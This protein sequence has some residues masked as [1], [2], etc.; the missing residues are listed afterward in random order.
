MKSFFRYFS[1]IGAILFTVISLSVL[2]VRAQLLNPQMYTDALEESGVYS[3]ISDILETKTTSY[4]ISAQKQLVSTIAD[5]YNPENQVVQKLEPVVVLFLDS[6]IDRETEKA[7]SQV[8]EKLQVESALKNG[9]AGVITYSVDWLAGIREDPKFLSYIPDPERLTEIK[10]QGAVPFFVSQVKQD[11]GVEDLPPCET[12]TQVTQNLSTIAQGKISDVTCYS[13]EIKAVVERG[14]EVAAPKIA[15]TQLAMTVND[16]LE[17]YQIRTL[18]EDLFNSL[19]NIAYLKQDLYQLREYVIQSKEWAVNGFIISLIMLVIGLILTEKRRIKTLFTVYLVSG[20]S[21]TVWA[22]FN[23]MSLS[24]LVNKSM[25]NNLALI[26][27]PAISTAQKIALAN[28][29]R[30]AGA[31]IAQDLVSG[32]L[33]IGLLM[34]AVSLGGL[35]VVKIFQKRKSKKNSNKLSSS[36]KPSPKKK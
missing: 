22:V 12:V 30:Q 15:Q 7:V 2:T 33:T 18:V 8:F 4:L 29:I 6:L 26:T 20:I 36:P 19:L 9:S 23:M 17:K 21:M 35:I 34:V 16:Y 10:D 24:Y 13:P 3:S 31:Y 27:D 28:S 11:I 1:L 25:P 5:S 14:A 32:M